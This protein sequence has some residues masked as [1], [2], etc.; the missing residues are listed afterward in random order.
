MLCSS[1]TL[2][3]EEER[4]GNEE[5]REDALAVHRSPSLVLSFFI[6]SLIP[7]V[8]LSRERLDHSEWGNEAFRA[9]GGKIK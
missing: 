7:I 9:L 3:E 8:R 1:P 6:E 2:L 4:R 5:E